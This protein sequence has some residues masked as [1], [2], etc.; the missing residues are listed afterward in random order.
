MELRVYVWVPEISEDWRARFRLLEN[1]KDCFDREGIE[2]PFPYLKLVHKKD[3][4]PL[5]KKVLTGA[6]ST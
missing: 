3:L 4:P 5:R 1:I 6:D 2:I